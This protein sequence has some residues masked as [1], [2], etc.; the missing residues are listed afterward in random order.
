ME[1]Y[2]EV[3]KVFLL[4]QI[5]AGLIGGCFGVRAVFKHYLELYG[6]ELTI[7]FSVIGL[8]SAGGASEYFYNVQEV[9]SLFLHMLIGCGTGILGTSAVDA[10]RLAA[11][12]LMKDLVNNTGESLIEKILVFL[13]LRK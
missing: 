12:L 2:I 3:L 9:T 1:L 5:I 10:I 6:W 13:K 4:P 7:T 8:I 11:P